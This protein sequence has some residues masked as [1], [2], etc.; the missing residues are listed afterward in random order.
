MAT[1]KRNRNRP[2]KEQIDIKKNV[3]INI[4]KNRIALE[5]SKIQMVHGVKKGEPESGFQL[6]PY[7]SSSSGS[8]IDKE[9]WRSFFKEKKNVAPINFFLP[10][11]ITN[12]LGDFFK[13][14]NIDWLDRQRN[15]YDYVGKRGTQIKTQAST[16][17]DVVPYEDYIAGPTI[18]T[19]QL[20]RNRRK[21]YERRQAE[22]SERHKQQ[23]AWNLFNMSDKDRFLKEAQE[24]FG[25]PERAEEAYKKELKKNLPAF[26]KESKANTKNLERMSKAFSYAKGIPGLG[27][28]ASMGPVGAGVALGTAAIATTTGIFNQIDKANSSVVRWENATRFYGAPSEDERRTMFLAGIGDPAKQSEIY[29]RLTA[30]FGSF[31]NAMRVFSR[32]EKMPD[33][34][35]KIMALQSMASEGLTPETLVM[36]GIYAGTT[37]PSRAR[38]MAGALDVQRVATQLG[39]KSGSKEGVVTQAGLMFMPDS[40]LARMGSVGDIF[41]GQNL[42]KI[43]Q[44]KEIASTG[45]KYD[46]QGAV[47]S[48][49]SN[50]TNGD[51]IYNNYITV[52]DA[53]QIGPAIESATD[54]SRK[55]VDRQKKMDAVATGVLQ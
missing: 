19:E 35:A 39:I 33:G 49:V 11:V 25:T 20:V 22:L 28:I 30:R 2:S 48:S 7:G 45:I 54:G 43:N 46:S 1:D 55:A 27:R 34:T 53:G 13:K 40:W 26:F 10:A 38:K 16:V 8:A 37:T 21:D 3:L 41:E 52:P 42:D 44:A 6:S 51:T 23:M 5:A 15:K 14:K 50:I 18:T 9:F 17:F 36:A 4:A 24:R 47:N 29:G 32:F 31:Q 12:P